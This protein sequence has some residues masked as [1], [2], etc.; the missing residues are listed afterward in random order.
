MKFNDLGIGKRLLAG[1]GLLTL[2]LL[3]LGVL[4]VSSMRDMHSVSAEIER[5]SIPSIQGIARLDHYFL[6]L[7]IYT[8]RLTST[9]QPAAQQAV[10]AE[11][12]NIKRSLAAAEAQFE[13]LLRSD[14]ERRTF[15]DYLK[16]STR[17]LQLQ[18][19]F[20]RLTFAGDKS[21]AEI[22]IDDLVALSNTINQHLE[23]L[24]ALNT[25]YANELVEKSE[26]TYQRDMKVTLLAMLLAVMLALVIAVVITK[27]ITR[28]LRRAVSLASAVSE[29][30][31]T[32][33]IEINSQDETGQLLQ[34]LNTMQ[35]KL[36]DA[37]QGIADSAMQLAS[38][39]EQ[40]NAVT[41]DGSQALQ[42]QNDE[43]QQAAAAV[44]EMSSA[45]DE[46]AHTA[47]QLSADSAATV[48]ISDAGQQQ[49]QDT[50]SALNKMNEELKASSAVVSGLAVQAKDIGQMLDVIRHI[51]E[52]T[53]LLA[54][55]AA[56][57]AAR[58]GDAGRGFAVVAD[59]VRALAQ[60]TQ[61]STKEI[62]QIVMSIQGGTG[63]AVQSIQHSATTAAQALLIAKSAGEALKQITLQIYKINDGNTI[64]ASAAEEQ[65]KVAREIDRNIINV[66]DLS[67]QTAAGASQASAAAHD[68]SRL[69][70]GL[71][72]LVMQFKL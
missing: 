48:Q 57:E 6:R 2:A 14:L 66:S 71:N 24:M 28:P 33:K 64:I 1:F 37:I 72:G 67:Q 49:V 69:A 10:V 62:E 32:R 70:T 55:N 65:A 54:L 41:A 9:V 42:Q 23:Q 58:A 7:R 13:Q 20:V 29:G 5:N 27:S 15:Q 61:Q 31:L 35:Q 51:A 52:Q 44:T 45:V 46:V 3:V 60:R 18:H 11:L 39:S 47:T 40:L 43:I 19:E 36:K 25:D 63:D 21:G 59:E 53:N 38:A 50:L 8:L 16:S 17:Y 30:D 22:L 56:I 26:I 34:A 12:D 68:L 4:A